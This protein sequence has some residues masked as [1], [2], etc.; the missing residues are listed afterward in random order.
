MSEDVYGMQMLRDQEE[1]TRLAVFV[2]MIQRSLTLVKIEHTA[3]S[4]HQV[5]R[6]SPLFFTKY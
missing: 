2:S 4:H 5:P 3:P 6:T 1:S